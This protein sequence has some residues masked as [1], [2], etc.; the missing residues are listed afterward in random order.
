MKISPVV[1][2]VS[3]LSVLMLTVTETA[4]SM[5]LLLL[6][7]LLLL[8]VVCCCCCCCCRLSFDTSDEGVFRA[9]FEKRYIAVHTHRNDIPRVFG[10]CNA[11][12]MERVDRESVCLSFSFS[13]RLT[14]CLSDCVAMCGCFVCLCF[15]CGFSCHKFM[16][17]FAGSTVLL[18]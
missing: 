6:W 8:F 13:V 1:S 4:T 10:A 5:L 11:N 15:L 18:F 17:L 3:H 14:F 7:L 2:F 9:T 12:A 16:R